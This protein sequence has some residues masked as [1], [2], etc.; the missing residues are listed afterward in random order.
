MCVQY[1]LFLKK[2]SIARYVFNICQHFKGSTIEHNLQY[3][4]FQLYYVMPLVI[5]T[6]SVGQTIHN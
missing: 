1:V 3:K 5:F 6:V 2:Y 4:T